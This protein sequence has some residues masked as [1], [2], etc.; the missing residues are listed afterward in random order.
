MCGDVHYAYSWRLEHN[1]PTP[2]GKKKQPALRDLEKKIQ[3]D[4]F[5]KF[6]VNGADLTV[7]DLVEKYVATKTAVRP[8]TKVGYQTVINMLNNENLER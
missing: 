7:N 1:D 5:E 3:A 2:K 6:A 8:T 4:V